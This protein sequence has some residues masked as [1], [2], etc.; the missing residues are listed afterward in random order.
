MGM[1]NSLYRLAM[2]VSKSIVLGS[3]DLNPHHAFSIISC[4]LSSSP[5]RYGGYGD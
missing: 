2:P 5:K 3:H 1:M 4:I